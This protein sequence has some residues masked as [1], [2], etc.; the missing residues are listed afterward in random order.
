MITEWLIYPTAI[1]AGLL[2]GVIGFG[3]SILLMP[4][5]VQLYG[6][7]KTIPDHCAYR[8]CCQQRQGLALVATC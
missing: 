4:F 7:I 3:T 5:L 8:H 1:A 2:G 6:P